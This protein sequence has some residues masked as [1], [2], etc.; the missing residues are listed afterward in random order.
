MSTSPSENVMSSTV[1]SSTNNPPSAEGE[2]NSRNG[3]A[4]THRE[5]S[6]ADA[7]DANTRHP[8]NPFEG[9]KFWSRLWFRWAYPIVRLGSKRPLED[10]DLP[11]LL[12]NETSAY[13]RDYFERLWRDE[14]ER[15]HKIQHSPGK[16]VKSISNKSLAGAADGQDARTIEPNLARAVFWDYWKRTRRARMFL[17]LNMAV[18]I[19]QTIALGRLL[20]VLE[21]PLEV[22]SVDGETRANGIVWASILV[23]CG[24]IAFPTKQQQFFETYR[25]G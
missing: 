13:Q 18:R 25:V 15:V 21:E 1:K 3:G 14:L 23:L 8:E 16:H 19:V 6:P 4:S 20:R 17:A 9:A 22:S 5:S 10:M 12:P 7:P 24:M 2:S 11:R